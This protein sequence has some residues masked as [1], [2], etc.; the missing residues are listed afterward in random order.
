MV[1]EGDRKGKV[2]VGNGREEEEGEDMEGN[3]RR[4][5]GMGANERKWKNEEGKEM[6]RGEKG[7]EEGR[8]KR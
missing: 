7:E 5:E 6:K 2:A 1:R 3:R 4:G 8:W